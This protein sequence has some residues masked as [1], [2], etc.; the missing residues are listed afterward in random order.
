MHDVIVRVLE[1]NSFV[2]PDV[3]NINDALDVDYWIIS[4]PKCSTTAIQRGLEG[5]GHPVLHLHTNYSLYGAYPNGHVLEE[6]GIGVEDLVKARLAS[7]PKKLHCFFGFRDTLSWWVSLAGQFSLDYAK[8]QERPDDISRHEFPWDKYSIDDMAA[9]IR[10]GFGINITDH[11]FDTEA[12]IS[13]LEHDRFNLVLY[14]FD[15]MDAVETYIK[16][17]IDDRFVMRQE[18]VNVDEKYLEFKSSFRPSDEAVAALN[19]DDWRS[20]FYG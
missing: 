17:H 10:E 5:I 6:A 1:N 16:T 7:S 2:N 19:D 11:A 15:R 8:L 14:R 18:R 13:V 12:G 9:I 20:Y 4:I 3:G